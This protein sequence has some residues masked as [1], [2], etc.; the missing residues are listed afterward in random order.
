[1][2]KT[3]L[4]IKTKNLKSM[5]RKKTAMPKKQKI[6]LE[7]TIF[8]AVL[9]SVGFVVVC[10]FSITLFQG[11]GGAGIGNSLQTQVFQNSSSGLGGGTAESLILVGA[12]AFCV[13]GLAIYIGLKIHDRFF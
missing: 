12:L 6:K 10:L 8:T 5:K 7:K 9:A 11:P 1:L 13:L 3:G 2:P 4:E